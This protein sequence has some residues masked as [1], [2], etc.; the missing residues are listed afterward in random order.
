[1]KLWS[2]IISQKNCATAAVIK[3]WHVQCKLPLW[4]VI[5]HTWHPSLD[6]CIKCHYTFSRFSLGIA[7]LMEDEKAMSVSFFVVELTWD[8]W[9][10]FLPMW[11]VIMFTNRCKYTSNFGL[12]ELF[13]IHMKAITLFFFLMK[14]QWPAQKPSV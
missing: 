14:K 9:L 8:V 2:V 11:P 12:S 3:Q 7:F 10:V 13:N 6:K 5:I 1:M 4:S